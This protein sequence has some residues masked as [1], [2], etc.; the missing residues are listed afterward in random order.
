VHFAC[1]GVQNLNAPL[2]SGFLL[3]N[4]CLE[5]SRI[6][7]TSLPNADFTF[8]S[9]CQTAAGHLDHPDEAIHLAAGMLLAGYHSVIATMWSISD[10][11]APFIADAVYSYLLVYCAHDFAALNILYIYNLCS[12]SE[13]PFLNLSPKLFKYDWLA[14]SWLTAFM[15]LRMPME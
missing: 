1:H 6:I 7:S 15:Q 11:D 4:G 12:N 13:F 8:L 9:A 2:K 5:L 3:Q 10:N 14:Q